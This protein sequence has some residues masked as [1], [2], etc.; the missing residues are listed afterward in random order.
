MHFINVLFCII[1]RIVWHHGQ[2]KYV[3]SDVKN[4]NGIQLKYDQFMWI[5]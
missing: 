3:A 4:S 5:T 1:F 2:S